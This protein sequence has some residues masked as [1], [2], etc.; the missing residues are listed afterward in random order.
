LLAEPYLTT[1]ESFC[2]Q[3]CYAGYIVLEI[4]QSETVN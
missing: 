2:A 3:G 1:V 4:E